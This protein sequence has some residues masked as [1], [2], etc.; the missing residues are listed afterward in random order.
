MSV[1]F[2]LASPA[3]VFRGARISSLPIVKLVYK[4]K[5]VTVGIASTKLNNISAD[6]S[7]RAFV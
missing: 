7:V 4:A 5:Y 6:D 3:G 2:V 1:F